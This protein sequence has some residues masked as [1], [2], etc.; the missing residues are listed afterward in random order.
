MTE[1]TEMDWNMSDATMKRLHENLQ[2]CHAS[3]FQENYRAWINALENMHVELQAL[4]T[5]TDNVEDAKESLNE[6][7]N[8]MTGWNPDSNDI[9]ESLDQATASLLTAMKNEGLLVKESEGMGIPG[10][11]N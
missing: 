3:R 5:D 10:E 11:N 8:E 2:R 6:A 7:D 4:C 9:R 1:D